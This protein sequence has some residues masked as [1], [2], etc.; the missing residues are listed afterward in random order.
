MTTQKL[1]RYEISKSARSTS[2][3]WTIWRVTPRGLHEPLDTQP[4][5]EQAKKY[6]QITYDVDPCS[7]HQTA[8]RFRNGY[9]CWVGRTK[10]PA[11]PPA[12]GGKE[13]E[14]S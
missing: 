8:E 11:R 9:D 10:G 2:I 4:S 14:K 12:P 3:G 6:C 7:W 1:E 13:A 5:L